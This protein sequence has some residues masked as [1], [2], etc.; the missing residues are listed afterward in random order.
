M[1]AI[2]PD[3]TKA[4]KG[5]FGLVWFGLVWF[6]ETGYPGTLCFLCDRIKG[7]RCHTQPGFRFCALSF[8]L[9]VVQAGLTFAAVLLH[10]PQSCPEDTYLYLCLDNFK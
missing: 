3:T 5:W 2:K 9:S 10:E 1:K 6:F 8:T 7:E 4:Q